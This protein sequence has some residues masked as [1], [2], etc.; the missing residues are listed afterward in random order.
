MMW[1]PGHRPPCRHAR[2]HRLLVVCALFC[3]WST[4]AAAT[5]DY[6]F[7]TC[8]QQSA[9]KHR[10]PV[11]LLLAVARTE[12]AFDAGASSHA[13]AHGVMQIQWPGT[14][15]HLGV[16]RIAELFVPCRS[17]ELGATYLR[18]L[19]DR[20]EQ[21]TRRALAAYNYGPGRIA[22][23]GAIPKGA[24]KYVRLVAEHRLKFAPHAR[25]TRRSGAADRPAVAAVRSASTTWLASGREFGVASFGR[26]THA[27]ALAAGLARRLNAPVTVRKVGTL[28][29][30]VLV[31][32]PEAGLSKH[33]I[34]V[35]DWFGVAGAG[36]SAASVDG[37]CSGAQALA[38]WGQPARRV[39]GNW[40]QRTNPLDPEQESDH[41]A[42]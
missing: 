12:S 5:A 22:R 10:V 14:A 26:I 15:R 35:L 40:L 16:R 33:A 1:F 38:F 8:F 42:S 39:N 9:A 28:S 32:V 30:V 13:N 27:D 25:A 36:N 29:Y 3:G 11:D 41:Q 23:T 7:A 21:D 6:P 17:I 34:R 31:R 24:D 37:S 20:Y 19:L 4:A 18:E 2:L